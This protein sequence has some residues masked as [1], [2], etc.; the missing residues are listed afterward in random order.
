MKTLI[1]ATSAKP[2]NWEEEIANQRRYKL[3]YL[4]LSWELAAPY[5]DYDPPGIHDHKTIR[6]LEEALRFDFYWAWQ[7][8]KKVNKNGYEAVVT[9][10]ERVSVPLAHLLPR[11]VKQVAIL[12]NPFSR[13]WRSLIKAVQPHNR[14]DAIITYSQAEAQALQEIFHIP[15]GKIHTILNYVDVDFFQPQ[16]QA[17]NEH[18]RPF[19]LSQGLAKRDYPT[20][21]AAM[22][23]LPEID[24]QISAT[25]AWDNYKTGYESL[26]I[27][28]NVHIKSYDH[29][30]VIRQSMEE[31]QFMVISIYPQIGQWCTGSTSVLQ[32]QAMGKPVIVTAIPGICEYVQDGR[33]GFLVDGQNPSDMAQ[34]IDYLWR[35]PQESQAMGRQGQE[36]VRQNFSLDR[37]MQQM[38]GLLASLS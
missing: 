38:I 35:H 31:S 28:P 27:P 9:H 36:W 10:S 34:K 4:E 25:S 13:K 33:T 6:K 23:R 20:L 5:I 18:T 30:Y 21:I 15:P 32:A 14:W 12:I 22:R 17:P 29:P 7:I 3:E 26:E 1:I 19:I 11:R 2:P 16:Y 37:W 8:A 24:C